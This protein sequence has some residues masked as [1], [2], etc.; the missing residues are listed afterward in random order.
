[1]RLLVG[2]GILL[3]EAADAPSMI[4]AAS[5]FVSGVT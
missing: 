5:K 4:A 2:L 1:M 3:M